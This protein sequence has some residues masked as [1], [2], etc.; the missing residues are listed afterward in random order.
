M[1][2]MALPSGTLIVA[3]QRRS[4]DVVGAETIVPLILS[5]D[6]AATDVCMSSSI[7]RSINAFR[8]LVSRSLIRSTLLLWFVYFAFCFAYYGIVL[9]TSELS[10]GGRRC[11]PVGMHLWQRNDARLYRDVLVT[12][13]AGK[14]VK[15]SDK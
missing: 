8:T 11:G 15:A 3:P 13:I 4:D 5:Q 6:S 12:S 1:N 10:N 2:N 14:C 7:S 9:L